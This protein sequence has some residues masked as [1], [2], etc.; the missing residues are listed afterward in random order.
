VEVGAGT[1]VFSLLACRAGARR[2][3]AI[4]SEDIIQFARELAVANGF[5]DRIEFFEGNS[6]VTE[7]PERANVVIVCP[8]LNAQYPRS[9]TPGRG[10]SCQV[11]S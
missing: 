5:C 8:S 9:K 10:S 2:V 6:R 7:L 1:E 4:E 11:A 3:F